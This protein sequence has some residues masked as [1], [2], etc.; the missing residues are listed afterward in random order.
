MGYNTG[1]PVGSSDPRD[2]L[3]NSQILDEVV[4]GAGASVPDRRGM[5]DI[6]TLA[7]LETLATGV[8]AV[9]ASLIAQAAADNAVASANVYVDVATGRAAV[10]DGQQFAVVSGAEIVRYRRDSSSTQTEVARYPSSSGAAAIAARDV[11]FINAP[12]PTSPLYRVRKIEIYKTLAGVAVTLPAMIG[13]RECARDLGSGGRF[14]FR[15][16]GFDG[17]S[18][19]TDLLRERGNGTYLAGTQNG[20]SWV[21]IEASSTALGLPVGT[22]LGRVLIDFGANEA[23]GSYATTIAWSVGGILPSHQQ[24]GTV[25]EN[26]TAESINRALSNISGAKV[27]FADEVTATDIRRLVRDLRLYNADKSHEYVVSVLTVETFATPI[28]RFRMTIRDITAGVDVCTVAKSV[29]S[30]PGWAS[31]VATLQPSVKLTSSGLSP[32]ANTGI[33]AVATLDWSAVSNFFSYGSASVS[34]AGISASRVYSD[35]DIADYLDSD[36]VDEVITVGASGAD[37]TTLRAAVESTYSW[38]TGA[39]LVNGAPICDRACYHHRVLIRMIDDATYDAT[40]LLI[41]EWVELQGNGYGR[42]FVQRENTDTD[43]M[44]E[45]HLCGKMRDFSIVSESPIEYCIHSDDFNRNAFGGAGQNRFIR[46]S[47]K[48]MRLRGA[49]GHSGYLFGGG[50]SS[51]E[52][53]LFDDVVAGHDDP[54]VMTDAFFWHNTGP[55]IST[56]AVNVGYKPSLIE[57]RGCSSP[58]YNG[59]YLQSLHQSGVAVLSMRDCH[60]NRVQH[61]IPSGEVS[62]SGADRIQWEIVGQYDGPWVNGDGDADSYTLEWAPSAAPKRRVINSTGASIPKGRFVRFTGTG[63]V[64]LCGANERPEAWTIAAIADGADGDVILTRRIDDVYIDG[65]ESG[66]GEWGISAGGALDYSAAVKLGR[67]VAG[68]VEVF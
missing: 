10:S 38:V 58:N 33:Y 9:E 47:F 44:L 24:A 42:T 46:Q 39:F 32:A 21:N 52:H 67:V 56:P 43:A 12:L 13:I 7:G 18:T 57:M 49:D 16:A 8:P 34:L 25:A 45:M 28:T 27:P 41:P 2:L 1:N 35:G 63:T 40:F 59:I 37:Y 68:V 65:A 17:V 14:R 50:L 62:G 51:G 53:I 20:A 29:S 4:N 26:D 11:G 3:D 55:T 6:V 36:R 66:S 60:F 61:Q 31:F 54:T 64:A 30:Q 19:Y 5:R 48:R 15:L 23:F 22:L